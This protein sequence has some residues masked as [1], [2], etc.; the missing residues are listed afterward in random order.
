M[1]KEKKENL[2][3]KIS[4]KGTENVSGGEIQEYRD[5]LHRRRYK[6]INDKDA[7]TIKY[8]LVKLIKSLK[9]N[10]IIL[11]IVIIIC[12]LMFFYI[13]LSFCYIFKNWRRS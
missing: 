3:G 10:T 9:R 11:F 13:L 6:L 8:E 7:R 1:S 5:L 12:S 4:D 2:V